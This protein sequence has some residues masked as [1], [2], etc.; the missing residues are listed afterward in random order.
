MEVAMK[1]ISRLLAILITL[2]TLPLTA[3][4]PQA[5]HVILLVEEN[6]SYSAVM[7]GGMPYLDSLAEQYGLATNYYANTH[8]SIGNYFVLTTGQILTNNDGYSG[9][10]DV[11]NI[12]RHLVAAGKTWKSYAESLPSPGYVGGNEGKYLKRHNP[13]AYLADVVNNPA[14]RQNIVPFTQLATDIRNN[15]LP[16]YAFIAPNRCNDAHDCPISTADEWL[17]ANIGPLIASPAFQDGGLLIIT[18]DESF[19]SDRKHGGGQVATVIVGPQVKHGFKSS[20]FYQHQST[21]RLTME[22]LGLNS[23]P[24]MAAS[25]PSMAE[26]FPSAARP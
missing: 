16:D 8:P 14:Q 19:E 4:T 6:Q 23:S 1:A 24:G 22:S 5:K 15:T 3:Q 26:F 2:C 13:F 12:V 17:K 10:E 9:T 20:T 7:N 11:D 25:A 21:L 18:F